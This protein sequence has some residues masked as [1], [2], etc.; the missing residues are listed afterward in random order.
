MSA[1]RE[2]VRRYMDAFARGDHPEVPSCLTDDVEWVI[3]GALDEDIFAAY[4]HM[5]SDEP[6]E[7]EAAEWC[8]ALIPDVSDEAP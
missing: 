3:P 1:N 4:A 6:R 8:N 5:A 2:T 7:S